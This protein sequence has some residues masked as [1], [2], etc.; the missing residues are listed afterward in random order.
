M[1]LKVLTRDLIKQIP[2]GSIKLPFNFGSNDVRDMGLPETGDIIVNIRGVPHIVTQMGK[3]CLE[4]TGPRYLS[5]YIKLF[6]CYTRLRELT[7]GL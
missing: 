5:F 3:S 2:E 1:G 6:L 7:P 4:Y